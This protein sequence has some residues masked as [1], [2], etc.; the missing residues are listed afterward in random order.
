MADRINEGYAITDSIQ[1][2]DTEYVFGELEHGKI[3]M[4]VTWACKGRNNYFWGHYFT[5]LWRRKKTCWAAP[6]RNWSIRWSGERGLLKGSPRSRI[7]S[8]SGNG[9]DF[10]ARDPC[11]TAL[12]L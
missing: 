5:D 11:G 7:R 9:Y 4:Y 3:P 10:A 8:V 12:R 6:A 2:G 1:I